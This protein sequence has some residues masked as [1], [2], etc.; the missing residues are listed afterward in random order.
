LPAAEEKDG[1]S[2]TDLL[3]PWQ[4]VIALSWRFGAEL[5][6]RYPRRLTLVET[7]PNGIYDCLTVVDRA[8]ERAF[9]CILMNRRGVITI[10]VTNGGHTSG[11]QR[12]AWDEILRADDPRA[13]LNQL[14][15]QAHLPSVHLLP[16]SSP[17]SVTYRVIA[18]FLQHAMFGRTSRDCRSG[19]DDEFGTVMTDWFN[20]FPG[21]SERLAVREPDDVFGEPAT[22]FWFLLEGRTPVL[23]FEARHGKAWDTTGKET[24]LFAGYRHHG[25]LWPVVWTTTGH[26]LP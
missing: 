25:R 26:L 16:A 9:D 21:L 5:I 1:N 20:R 8:N 12:T 19:Y 11:E 2:V 7:H 17:E 22:R 4:V 24:D 13:P 10:V 23:A 18:A 15:E 14:C 6:R 3:P